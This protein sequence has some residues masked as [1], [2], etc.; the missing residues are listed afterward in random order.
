MVRMGSLMLALIFIL[1]E[2]LYVYGYLGLCDVNCPWSHTCGRFRCCLKDFW[3]R[4]LWFPHI[5]CHLSE[6]S[7]WQWVG[8]E[9][10]WPLKLLKV[11]KPLAGPL[12]PPILFRFNASFS[13]L[14]DSAS[15][16]NAWLPDVH[17][18]EIN[19]ILLN[20]ALYVKPF[21]LPAFT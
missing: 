8:S 20:N 19:W 5:T 10:R 16:R 6:A 18:I 4:S 11:Q 21:V 3:I 17:R 12:A 7:H 13:C 14:P 9:A 1:L 2:M 15:P